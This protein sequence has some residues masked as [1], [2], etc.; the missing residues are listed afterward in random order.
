M[1]PSGNSLTCPHCGCR[2]QLETKILEFPAAEPLALQ[3]RFGLSPSNTR[4]GHL[5]AKGLGYGEIADRMCTTEGAVKQ[6]AFRM[7]HKIGCAGREDFM[8]VLYAGEAR[9][10]NE[11]ANA[12]KV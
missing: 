12:K 10:A 2:L 6:M 9:W 11:A 8:K 3:A 1:T 4:L 7:F 5:I